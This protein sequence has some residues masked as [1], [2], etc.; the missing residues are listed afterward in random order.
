[1]EVSHLQEVQEH[2]MLTQEYAI[3]TPP[4]AEFFD[5][6]CEWIDNK[7]PGGYVYGMSRLGKSRAIRFWMTLLIEEK[8]Q[9]RV[10]FFN[11]H[12]RQHERP[13]E[14]LF[15][16]EILAALENIFATAGNKQAMYKRVISHMC[17]RAQNLKTNYVLLMIDEAQFMHEQ[18]YQ[19]LC[20]IHNALDKLGYRFTVISV[21]SHEL[22][23]QHEVFAMADSAYL[24]ARFMVRSQMFHGI[25]T[26][27]ELKYVLNGYDEQS[28]WPANSKISFT[29]Y[30][31]PRAFKAG[32]RIDEISE[33]MWEIFIELAPDNIK[34]Y[35][36]IPM[37][38]I[39]KSVEYLFRV[40]S[41][42]NPLHFT[43]E[44]DLIRKAIQQTAY[45]QHMYAVS[46]I[47]GRK[48]KGSRN[49][50]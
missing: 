44:E 32:F 16:S 3:Y 43:I 26:A 38:H 22:T 36:N 12:Y 47:L 20:N 21:G 29:H 1:M 10:A 50:S 9:G 23:Y 5:V 17:T 46:L 24:M 4:I 6:I 33:Q 39:A 34:K 41:P 11:M 18:E 13:S 27:A 42:G 19:W 31:F 30:F 35:L 45:Q 2:P 37:E 25:R 49:E 14:G 7:V 8:Y 28:E 40:L 48:S 15:L